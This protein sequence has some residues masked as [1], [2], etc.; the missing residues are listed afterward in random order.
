MASI[1]QVADWAAAHEI[2]IRGACFVAVFALIA[3]W[4]FRAPTRTLLLSKRL[5]WANNLGLVALNT[6]LIRLLFPAA[7]P[8][9]VPA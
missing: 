9:A 7:E 1:A 2:L 5:R 8:P 3:I 6:V 4:E